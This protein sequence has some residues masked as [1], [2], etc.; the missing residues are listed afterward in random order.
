MIMTG[1][2]TTN[3]VEGLCRTGVNLLVDKVNDYIDQLHFGD[4]QG[5]SDAFKFG[6]YANI[7]LRNTEAKKLKDG[8]Y[9]GTLDLG[10]ERSFTADWD[11]EKAR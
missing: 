8:V 7:E 11:A 10:G 9:T 4:A 1:F 5:G 6:G 3:V 2:I